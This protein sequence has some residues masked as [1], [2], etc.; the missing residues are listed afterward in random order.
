LNFQVPKYVIYEPNLVVQLDKIM[1]S[2]L[3]MLHSVSQTID[4]EALKEMLAEEWMK[5]YRKLEV[6][7]E[8]SDKEWKR[9]AELHDKLSDYRLSDP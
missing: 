8:R 1:L 3:D 2:L 7:E 5:E 6:M 4:D 9:L